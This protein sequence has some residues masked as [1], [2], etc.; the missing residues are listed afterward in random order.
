MKKTGFTLLLALLV[1]FITAHVAVSDSFVNDS[2]IAALENFKFGQ[3]SFDENSSNS[4]VV[5]KSE[6]MKTLNEV[7]YDSFIDAS[8][9]AALENFKFGQKVSDENSTII[10]VATKSASKK[11]DGVLNTTN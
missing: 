10:Q 7:G 6:S 2:V 8:I 11:A 4:Q 9:V 3:T 5:N 1:I